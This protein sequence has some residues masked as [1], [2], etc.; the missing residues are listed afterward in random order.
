[1]F[2]LAIR[3]TKDKPGF[4]D[5]VRV[6]DPRGEATLTMEVDLDRLVGWL[7]ERVGYVQEVFPN[8]TVEEREFLISGTTAA[9]WDAM[10]PEEEA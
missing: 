3:P 10:F 7:Q 4:C 9:E 5:V 8:L 1:M 6:D 2:K